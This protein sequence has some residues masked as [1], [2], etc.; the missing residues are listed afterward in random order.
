MAARS[1]GASSLTS[2]LHDW[3]EWVIMGN[4]P[5]TFV[6]NKYAR[7]SSTLENIGRN[8]LGPL[9]DEIHVKM[10]RSKIAQELP[11]TF[12]IIF[13]GWECG[14]ENLFAYVCNMDQKQWFSRNV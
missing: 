4:Y 6:S 11:D 12:G 5:F 9:C 7:K 1:D 13:D 10:V 2:N 3:A 14:G 8:A